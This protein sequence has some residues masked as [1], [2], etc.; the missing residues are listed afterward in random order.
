M[1]LKKKM[2]ICKECKKATYI[3]SK[4]LCKQCASKNYKKIKNES[5]KRKEQ[6]KIYSQERLLFLEQF[7]FCKAQLENCTVR[8]TDIHHKKG[9]LG[10]LYLDTNYWLP[11]CRSCHTWIT[12]NPLKAI[13][14]GLSITRS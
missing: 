5:S 11:T 7:P 10:E 13:A 9:R 12:E 3:W 2:K 4:G 14:K 1:T 8:A 6:S